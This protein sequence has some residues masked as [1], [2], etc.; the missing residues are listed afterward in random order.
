M[1]FQVYYKIIEMNIK[2][3]NMKNMEK[4][5]TGARKCYIIKFFDIAKILTAF[6]ILNF[7]L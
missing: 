4:F 2:M 6:S 7:L 3:N 5:F 1:G